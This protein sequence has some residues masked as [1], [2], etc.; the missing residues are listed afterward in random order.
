MSTKPDQGHECQIRF[1]EYGGEPR[2]ADLAFVG[3]NSSG[4]VAITIEA[5]ADEP[6]GSTVAETFA[7]A[8]ERRVASP[9]SRGVE[10]ITALASALFRPREKNA[11]MVGDLHYQLLTAAA[12]TLAYAAANEAPTAVLVVHEFRTPA[13][14]D[15]RHAENER[16]YRTFL[17]RLGGTVEMSELR[18]GTLLGP[19]AVP[20]FP[21]F[22]RGSSLLIGKITTDRRQESRAE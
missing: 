16:A 17:A 19:I 11:P 13:T 3:A 5:K 21:L 8:L 20:G 15:Q 4:K 22:D 10:R 7:D 1:D 6:F 18:T 12:G 2:N 9:S 14:H